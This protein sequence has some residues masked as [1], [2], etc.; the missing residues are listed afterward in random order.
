MAWRYG[1]RIIEAYYLATP[2]FFLADLIFDAPVRAAAFH[3]PA[4]RYAYYIVLVGLGLLCRFRPRLAPVVGM[5]ESAANL[6]L[7]ILSIL[8]PIWGMADQVLA[9]EPVTGAPTGP[10]LVN[11]VLVG[12]MAIIA[13]KRNEGAFYRGIGRR[14]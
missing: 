3:A 2:L 1:D 14:R 12:G 13:F 10:Q 6:L 11:F 8:L 7:L 9:H 4:W 5:G